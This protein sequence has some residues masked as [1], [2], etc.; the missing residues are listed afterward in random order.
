MIQICCPLLVWAHSSWYR[1]GQD[2][3]P[4]CTH[5]ILQLL[6]AITTKVGSRWGNTAGAL[7]D[8]QLVATFLV[9]QTRTGGRPTWAAPG[10]TSG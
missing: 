8:Y 7:F 4:P 2:Y 6:L 10:F 1:G 3:R 5:D 9:T